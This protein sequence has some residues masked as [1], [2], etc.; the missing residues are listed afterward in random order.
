MKK[1]LLTICAALLIA[2]CADP[3]ASS[4]SGKIIGYNGEYT[5]FFLPAETPGEWVEIPIQVAEDGT[6]STKLKMDKDWWDAAL[7]VEKFMFRTCIERGKKYYAEFDI[8]IPDVED[9]F[10]FTGDGEKENEF[11][12]VYFNQFAFVWNLL[13]NM[14]TPADF[15]EYSANIKAKA[16][17][18]RAL[19]EAAANPGLTEYYTPEIEKIETMLSYYYPYLAL[20]RNGHIVEDA[21][22]ARFEKDAALDEMEPDKLQELFNGVASY[23][24]TIKGLDIVEATKLSKSHF[25]KKENAD[26][27]MTSL[28]RQYMG[29]GNT[30]GLRE[31]YEWYL[32][33][34]PADAY[35]EQVADL[36]KATMAL[37]PG[38]DAPEIELMDSEGNI[39]HLSD[40]F[41]KVLYIDFWA[42]WCGPCRG[43][44]PFME[45][46][47]AKYAGSKNINCIS[48]SLDEDIDAWKADV[49][50]SKPAWPQ[51]VL[52][53]KGQQQVADDYKISS[54]PR[55]VIIDAKGKIFDVNSQRPSSAGVCAQIESAVK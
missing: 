34:E 50:E 47:A 44:I 3:N 9:R 11:T 38:G 46:V 36:Y 35:I 20:A 53:E 33:Q 28:L 23:A 14:A 6:F 40:L 8:T 55:F 16:D 18:C 43:E 24:A 37:L 31:A 15:K 4:F 2:S 32:A 27:A 51:Y 17:E 39:L 48:I 26:F 54:I 29:V 41:G 5:E 25:T 12:R 10:H 49:A 22:F 19:M 52:T 45:K 30:E 42:T 13:D 1:I 7:F 21:D